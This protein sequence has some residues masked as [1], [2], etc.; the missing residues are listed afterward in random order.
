MQITF[1]IKMKIWIIYYNYIRRKNIK[2]K[3]YRLFKLNIDI[4]L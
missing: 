2:D 3:K 1:F 4:N